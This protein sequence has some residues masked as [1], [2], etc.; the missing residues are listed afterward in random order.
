MCP[1]QGSGAG[2]GPVQFTV[3]HSDFWGRGVKCPVAEIKRLK[4][5]VSP[6]LFSDV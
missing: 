2:P 4:Q 3:G 6:V 1:T 5:W